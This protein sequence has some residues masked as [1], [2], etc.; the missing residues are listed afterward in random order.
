MM[1]MIDGLDRQ[2]DARD[3]EIGDDRYIHTRKIH[4]KI[5]AVTGW[6]ITNDFYFS[7]CIFLYFLVFYNKHTLPL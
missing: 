6:G 7:S 3:R 2:A 4:I 5:M 1:M